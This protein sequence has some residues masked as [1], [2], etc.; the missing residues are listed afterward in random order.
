M[1][2]MDL[3]KN[4]GNTHQEAL[5]KLSE[6][7]FDS[8]DSEAERHISEKTEPEAESLKV[9]SRALQR[10]ITISWEGDNPAEVW[11]DGRSYTLAELAEMKGFDAQAVKTAHDMK[12]VF[13]GA[14][15][16]QDNAQA[17]TGPVDFDAEIQAVIEELDRAEI[18][19]PEVSVEIRR[20]CLELEDEITAAA[21][22][23]DVLEFRRALHAW[24]LAWLRNLH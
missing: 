15:I 24:R 11:V 1:K 5:P 22:Q 8:N 9:Y 12:G 10:E 17:A 23:D 3:L 20:E 16:G 6:P 18:V 2:Y 19:V 7:P 13:R 4:Q 14:R 21:N